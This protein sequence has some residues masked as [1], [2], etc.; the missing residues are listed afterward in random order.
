MNYLDNLWL[1]VQSLKVD[2][3]KVLKVPMADFQKV[4]KVDFLKVH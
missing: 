2:F 4:L 1:M 3:L